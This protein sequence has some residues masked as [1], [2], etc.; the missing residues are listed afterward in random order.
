MTI[1]M[2]LPRYTIVKKL[3][4]G[5]NAYY[6][7]CPSMYR[8]QNCPFTSVPLGV[9][10]S[11][12]EIA[13]AAAIWNARLDDWLNEKNPMAP[14]DLTRYGT[15]EWLVNAY[16]KHDAFLE[17]V[18]EFSRPDYHRILDRVVASEVVSETT[19]KT[20]R[21][22]DLA[23]NKV[24]V[25]TATSIYKHFI[26]TPRSAEKVF[27]YCKAMWKRMKPHHPDLF[28][29]DTPNPWEGVTLKKRT[30]AT[31]GHVDRATVYAFAE[32][33]I[34]KGRGELAAAAVLAFEWLMRPSSIG[35]GF[36][37]WG[38]YR[39]DSAT[40]KIIIGHRKNDQRASHPLEYVNEEGELV[41]LYAE[42][43]SVLKRTPRY[44]LSIVC[45]ASGKLFGDGARLAQEVRALAD[46]NG[47]EGFTIDKARHGGMT[48]LEEMGLTEGQG[49]VLSKH[50]TGTAYRGYAKETD[51]R[52]LEATKKRRGHSEAS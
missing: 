2:T 7:N 8:K 40:D 48:E 3:K 28:R 43:E 1:E 31:K 52:T 18:G 6:W 4:S 29:T 35:A 38:G 41:F 20:F 10:L 11:E 22:G 45:Q 49:R 24:G 51:K 39:G 21:T 13:E 42:A 23:I 12:R 36:A 17:N 50:K 25:S 9:G 14:V 47:F 33:A 26:D 15:V 34:E 27:T 16:L 32:M 5:S 19:G 46:D 44:G 37:A 30:K